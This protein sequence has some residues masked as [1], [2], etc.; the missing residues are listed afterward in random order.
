MD[1]M[2]ELCEILNKWAYEYYVLD[3]PSVSD[4]EYDKL[5]DE[6]RELERESGTVLPESPTRRV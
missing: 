3:N 5:Y 1:R 2:H 4:R 6:L